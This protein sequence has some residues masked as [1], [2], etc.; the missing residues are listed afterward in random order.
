MYASRR[1]AVV[2]HQRKYVCAALHSAFVGD[3]L[4]KGFRLLAIRKS[5]HPRS[6]LLCRS[7]D[8]NTVLATSRLQFTGL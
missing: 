4:S 6:P 5:V 8:L 1:G 2:N 7:L 3:L